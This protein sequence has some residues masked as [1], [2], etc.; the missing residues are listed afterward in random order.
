MQVLKLSY[1]DLLAILTIAAILAAWW[2]DHQRLLRINDTMQQE[3]FA[4]AIR[5]DIEVAIARRETDATQ[6]RLHA[7]MQ[8]H[9]PERIGTNFEFSGPD[10]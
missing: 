6:Q 4:S 8:K 3:H 10:D 1:R 2:A 9:E 5:S 7:F